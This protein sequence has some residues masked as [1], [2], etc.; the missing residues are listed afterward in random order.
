MKFLRLITVI[1][2]LSVFSLSCSTRSIS[3]EEKDLLFQVSDLSNYN[4][5][6]VQNDESE[7][8]IYKY[9]GKGSWDIKYTYDSP[10]I[11]D[12]TSL[13]IVSRVEF[14]SN[15]REAK[16]TF[17]S[18]IMAYKAGAKIG[19]LKYVEQSE[20]FKWG[21]ETYCA[22]IEKNESPVGNLIVVRKDNR[23][24]TFM[25]VGIYFDQTADLSELLTPKLINI[26]SY[27]PNN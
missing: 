25:V 8:F 27:Q 20:L 26:A 11:E 4:I 13:Y 16:S 24:F 2:I 21:D 5:K 19:G 6:A 18:G 3:D 17:S 22:I 15:V 9:Y 12:A 10:D 14:E 7:K 23:I 1:F